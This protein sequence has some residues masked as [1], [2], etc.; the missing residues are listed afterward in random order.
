MSKR[1]QHPGGYYSGHEH[2]LV[3]DHATHSCMGTAL[4]AHAW[5]GY[6]KQKGKREKTEQAKRKA[7]HA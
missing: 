5:H 3:M 2:L 7:T 6:V 1:R 4:R